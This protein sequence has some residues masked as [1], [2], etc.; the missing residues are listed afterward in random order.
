MC[1]LDEHVYRNNSLDAVKLQFNDFRENSGIGEA[2]F[3]NGTEFL[4]KGHVRFLSTRGR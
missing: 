4:Q 2:G 3:N 1:S